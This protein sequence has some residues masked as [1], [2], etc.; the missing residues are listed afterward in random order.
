LPY[1]P[2]AMTLEA[3]AGENCLLHQTYYS[4]GGGFII[5]QAEIDALPKRA[6]WLD[7]LMTSPAAKNYWSCAKPMALA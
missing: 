5:E 1:H 4:I 2:N 7:C 6:S 3:L